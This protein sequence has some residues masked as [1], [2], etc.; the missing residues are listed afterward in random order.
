MPDCSCCRSAR[1]HVQY[2]YHPVVAGIG[3][4]DIARS[5]HRPTGA[6]YRK[7]WEV[8]VPSELWPALPNEETEDGKIFF[9]FSKGLRA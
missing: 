6:Q 4:E 2:L 7:A 5:I 9:L 8:S 3:D 1:R